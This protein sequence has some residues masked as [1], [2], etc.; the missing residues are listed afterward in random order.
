V[1]VVPAALALGTNAKP[2]AVAKILSVTPPRN[3][4]YFKQN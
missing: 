1:P 2:M 4:F 3:K